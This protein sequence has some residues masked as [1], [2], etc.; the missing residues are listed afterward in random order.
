MTTDNTESIHP[1]VCPLDCP[2]T[3]SLSVTVA[4]DR[5]VEVRGSTV[6]PYTDGVICNK[7]SRYYPEFVHGSARLRTPLQ[8]VG[9]RGEDNFSPISWDAAIDLVYQGFNQAIDKFGPQS[10]MPFNYA[11]PHG[12]LAGGSMDRRFFHKMGATLLNRGPLCGAVRGAAYTSLYGAAPGMPPE[13]AEHADLII[14]WGNNV[15]VS[16][17]HLARVLK[18]AR[19][20]DARVI[21]IDP[22]RTRI[23]EQCHLHL[24]IQPGSDVVLAMATAAELE[25]RG[26]LDLPFIAEWTVGFDRYMAQARQYTVSDVENI[27]GLSAS[28]FDTFC[29]M[30][31]SATTVAASFGNGIERGHSG[32][33]GLRAAMA[34][35][36]TNRKPWQARCR[37]YRKSRLVYTQNHRSLATA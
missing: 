5:L 11:G 7:V 3:C 9:R 2:D 36:A 16:N 35:Q 27:C 34:L 26:V 22:K 14:V 29:S 13:Q 4:G 33:S 21:I 23:A 20:K 8:R 12:E 24:M 1:S 32:G 18:K 37:C 30:Y 10:V 28:E 6:N 31:A 17:L 19:D 15:T 25:R